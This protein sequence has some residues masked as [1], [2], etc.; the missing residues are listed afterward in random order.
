MLAIAQHRKSTSKIEEYTFAHT[1]WRREMGVFF[2]AF[3]AGERGEVTDERDDA[4]VVGRKAR[5][6]KDDHSILTKL[7]P[8]LELTGKTCSIKKQLQHL[9]TTLLGSSILSTPSVLQREN[10]PNKEKSTTAS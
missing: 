1:R 7:E 8:S 5:I 3:Q 2:A 10:T 9:T 6:Q 4:V